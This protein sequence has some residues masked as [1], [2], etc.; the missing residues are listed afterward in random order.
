MQTEQRLALLQVGPTDDG[1]KQQKCASTQ[2]CADAVGAEDQDAIM[3]DVEE[4]V[5]ATESV[6]SVAQL[7]AQAGQ[8]A[9]AASR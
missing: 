5:P 9:S 2:Q 8:V 7:A 1:S 3:I 4:A 6:L